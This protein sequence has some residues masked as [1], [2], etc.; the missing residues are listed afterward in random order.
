MK[1]LSLITAC[2]LFSAATISCSKRVCYEP[3][4]GSDMTVVR[5]CTGTYLQ[6]DGKDYLVC[7]L[8]AVDPFPTGTKVKASFTRVTEC[9]EASDRIVCMMFHANEGWIQVTSIR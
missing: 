9:K 4:A 2:L 7:N 1:L 8:S 5:D 6:Q 3:P